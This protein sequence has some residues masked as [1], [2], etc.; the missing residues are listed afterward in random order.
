MAAMCAHEPHAPATRYRTM[1][2]ASIPR[3]AGAMSISRFYLCLVSPFVLVNTLLVCYVLGIIID[4]SPQNGQA[5]ALDSGRGKFSYLYHRKCHMPTLCANT[6]ARNGSP[7]PF[8]DFSNSHV[9]SYTM[10]VYVC[11]SHA[12]KNCTDSSRKR[13]AANRVYSNKIDLIWI[14]SAEIILSNEISLI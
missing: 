10:F 8:N 3:D 6:S 14:F 5:R 2:G 12:R 1:V 9:R 11:H 4:R 13:S 7:T